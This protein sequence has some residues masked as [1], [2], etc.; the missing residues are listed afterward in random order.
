MSIKRMQQTV[1]VVTLRACVRIAPSAPATEALVRRRWGALTICFDRILG[2]RIFPDYCRPGS[3]K[4]RF[5]ALVV[6]LNLYLG[7]GVIR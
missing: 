5:C 2:S 6:L 3:E 4:T 7:L 1:T